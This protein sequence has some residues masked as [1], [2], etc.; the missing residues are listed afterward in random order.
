MYAMRY[1]SLPVAHRTGGLSDT[2]RDL[3]IDPVA[4]NG[5]LFDDSSTD[6]LTGALAR[7]AGWYYGKVGH[8]EVLRRVMEE[9]HSWRSAG[10]KYLALFDALPHGGKEK[11]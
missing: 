4:G 10:R 11:A 2:V 6:G 1:G 7:A 9:D 5:F 8:K 3:T